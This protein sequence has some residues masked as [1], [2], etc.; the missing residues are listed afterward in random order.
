VLDFPAIVQA[1]YDAGYTDDWW[2]M[3][4]CFWPNALEATKPALKFMQ[5]LAEEYG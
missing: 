4:L 5:G 2:P 3:D 1:L